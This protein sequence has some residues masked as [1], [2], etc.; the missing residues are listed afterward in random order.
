VDG[1][2]SPGAV[3]EADPGL[4][5]NYFVFLAFFFTLFSFRVAAG[6]FFSAFFCTSPF[7]ITFFLL[8]LKIL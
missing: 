1:K 4:K 6:F 5:K 8:F 2:K 3:F 7:A